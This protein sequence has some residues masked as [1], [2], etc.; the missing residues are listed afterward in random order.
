MDKYKPTRIG[1]RFFGDRAKVALL[2][3]SG[4]ECSK[5]G[6]TLH[7]GW[8][9]DHV[10]PWSKGGKTDV[11]NGQALCRSCNLKK[12][13]RMLKPWDRSFVLRKWQ[14]EA[15]TLWLTSKPKNITV[16][17]TP[18]AGKTVFGHRVAHQFLGENQGGLVVVVAPTD[19]LRGQWAKDGL[20]F[21][22]Q[23]DHEW[24]PSQ[25]MPVS[26]FHGVVVTYAAIATGSNTDVLRL[27]C[28]RR[29]VLVIFDE[30]HRTSTQKSWGDGIQRAFDGAAFRILMSGTPWRRIPSERIPFVT[31]DHDG[32]LVRDFYYSY[33]DGLNSKV[34]RPL[35]F[36]SIECSAKYYFDGDE[37]TAKFSECTSDEELSR[38]LNTALLPGGQ[39]MEAALKMGDDQITSDRRSHPDAGGLVLA[40]NVDHAKEIV[41]VLRKISGES[42]VLVASGEEDNSDR[43]ARFRDSTARWIVAVRMVSEGVD[44]KRL[45]V[46]VY[47][48]NVTDSEIFFIQAVNRSSR[49]IGKEARDPVTGE[50]IDI[51]DE[52]GTIIIP[53]HP[54][55]IAYAQ[56]II[57][58]R[59]VRLAAEIEKVSRE[60]EGD[61]GDE[62]DANLSTFVP[63]SSTPENA[64]FIHA[65]IRY[66]EGLLADAK[67]INAELFGENSPIDEKIL[68]PCLALDRSKR[69][70]TA[71]AEPTPSP[72]PGEQSIKERQ[73]ELRDLIKSLVTDYKIK[74]GRDYE[75]I[76]RELNAYSG[77]K[78]KK[79]T[80]KQL[81]KRREKISQMIQEWKLANS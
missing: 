51:G 15:Y 25:G 47:A 21:G 8:H 26:D 14:H 42:P 16:V 43:I 12:G 68:A 77:A 3:A 52:F 48:T 41:G 72:E 46:V 61:E 32:N 37:Y 70:A 18:G 56:N 10:V 78:T 6:V 4:G 75:E 66:D 33:T 7:K 79:A 64:G 38:C 73:K 17:A 27:I 11:V 24:S 9:A 31:Y 80:I 65:G 44:I 49:M 28:G 74:S 45:R 22:L 19:S 57:A 69:G 54:K 34:N 55:L 67:R 30:I 50:P 60:C 23:Y 5:C 36:P 13:N 58:E 71:I 20:R 81:V 40:K 29:P 59:E 1:P 76:H 39:W 2:L 53:N 62:W 35:Y 63:I